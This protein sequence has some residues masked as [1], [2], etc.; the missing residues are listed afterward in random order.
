MLA[1][2]IVAE[3]RRLLAED[4]LSQRKIAQ[5]L[6]VSRMTVY[7]IATGKRPDYE[8]RRSCDDEEPLTGPPRRCPGCGGMV[9]QPCQ[10]CRVRQLARGGSSGRRLAGAQ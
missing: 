7:M 2:Y 8:Q 4:R 1:P 6:G 9:L 10:L 5:R 3:I